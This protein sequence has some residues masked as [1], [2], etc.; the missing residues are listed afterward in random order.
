MFFFSS[1][2]IVFFISFG[3]ALFH[4]SRAT[5]LCSSLNEDG[6]VLLVLYDKIGN[7]FEK[8]QN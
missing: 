3:S 6:L 5:I 1:N 7:T 8:F 2:F 4:G